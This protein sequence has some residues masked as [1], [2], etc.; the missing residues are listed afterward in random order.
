M[1]GLFCFVSWATSSVDRG[2]VYGSAVVSGSE[3]DACK[4]L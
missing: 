3:G 4:S 1:I 2:R